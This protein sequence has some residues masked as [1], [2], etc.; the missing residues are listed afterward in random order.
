VAR[1]RLCHTAAVRS[2]SGRGLGVEVIG[3]LGEL[4]GQWDDLVGRMP[5]PSPFLRSW[6]LE[7]TGTGRP[8]TVLVRRDGTLV[9]GLALQADRVAGVERLRFRGGGPLEPDHLDLVALPDHV[10]EVVAAVAGWLGRR[11]DRVIDL[12]G[13]DGDAWLLDAVPGLGTVTAGEVAPYVEL[14]DRIETYLASRGGRMR[15]TITRTAKRLHRQGVE[16]RVVPAS[17]VG[18]ALDDLRRLHDGRW[19]E[20][21]GFL[22]QWD[23][24]AAAARAGAE[25]GEVRFTELVAPDEGVVAIEVDFVVAGR[26][27]FYQAGRRTEHEWRGAGSVLRAR[28]IEDAIA[29]GAQ[30]FDLLRGGEPY[31]TEW[32]DGSRRLHRVRRGVGPRGRAVVAAMQVNQWVRDRRPA[33]DAAPS[34]PVD[35]GTGLAG[36]RVVIYT[37]ADQIGGAERQVGQL[38]A[39]LDP[40]LGVTVVGTDRQVVDELGAARPGAARMVLPAIRHKGDVRAMWAHRRAFVALA[41]DLVHAQLGYGSACLFAMVVARTA[42]IPV[43]AT[44]HSPMGVWSEVARQVKRRLAPR[45]AAHVAVGRAAAATIAADLGLAADSLRVV[46]NGVAPLE[47]VPPER[48]AEGPT[49]GVVAR[50]DPVKGVDVA[51]DAL[52][53]L[54]GVTLVVV[55]DGPLRGDLEERARAIGV[56]DRV[57]FVGWVDEPRHLLPTFDVA[58]LPSRLEGMPVAV[59]EAMLAGVAVVATDV[60]SVREVVEHGVSGLVV[61]PEDPGA[62]AAAVRDL[63]DDP[64]RRAELAAAGRAV[65]AERFTAAA[66]VAAYEA[67]YREVLGV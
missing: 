18:R 66:Y 19:G 48:F 67:L 50:F 41:P 24:F 22:S 36:R 2:G 29:E 46:P 56:A 32:A 65:A 30:T 10:H 64:D 26:V 42:G 3:P 7:A 11:G 34:A 58:V 9:G 23:A 13:L 44:E 53:H 51:I 43:V 47:L 57:R 54:D 59:I 45:L 35:G 21:S 31:K 40:E 6:W 62:L 38:L 60:G 55:G 15:S 8:V 63:L 25:R 39:G 28:I 27:S 16:H 49:I 1:R 20:A 33:S 5:R 14:P 52:A 61:R 4:A 12:D 37:D 17:D